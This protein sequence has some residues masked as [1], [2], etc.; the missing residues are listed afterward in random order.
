MRIGTVFSPDD[1][2]IVARNMYRKT[3]NILKNFCIKLVLFTRL[4]KDVRSTKHKILVYEALGL[5]ELI[6][7]PFVITNIDLRFQTVG[8]TA[9]HLLKVDLN[10]EVSK[11]HR[12]N[13]HYAM[14]VLFVI[15]LT[16]MP[17]SLQEQK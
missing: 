4:Y 15:L 6:L 13:G 10:N 8:I 9:D 2:H 5:K 16:C 12:T 3:I 14:F 7:S 17:S 1:G 11:S